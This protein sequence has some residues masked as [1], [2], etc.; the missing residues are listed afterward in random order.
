[1]SDPRLRRL[2]A[3]EAAKLI[4][5]GAQSEYPGAKRKLARR[6]GLDPRHQPD[7]RATAR[8]AS[9]SS[10]WPSGSKATAAWPAWAGCGGEARA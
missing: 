6:Y 4:C 9:R 2:I 5:D 10:A 3:I 7:S 8:S 1:M